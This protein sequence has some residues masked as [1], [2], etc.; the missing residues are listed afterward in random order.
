MDNII[1]LAQA[2]TSY[3]CHEVSGKIG[4]LDSCSEILSN[5]NDP[6]VQLQ[7]REILNLNANALSSSIEF[8]RQ[9]YGL[10]SEAEQT[11]IEGIK[12]LCQDFLG[13][14]RIQ[15]EFEEENIPINKNLAKLILCLVISAANNLLKEGTIFINL[16]RD[17]LK[18]SKI[19]LKVLGTKLKIVR[20]KIDIMLE[21]RDA[22]EISIYTAHEYY[23]IHLAKNLGIKISINQTE[24]LIEYRCE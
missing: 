23:L 24:D 20:N 17:N 12:R 15:F 6:S 7:A 18:V 14:N 5:S 8:Y 13:D 19:I 1:K 22:E 21:T 2:L 3:L 4:A 10:S 16:V 11:N 9:A